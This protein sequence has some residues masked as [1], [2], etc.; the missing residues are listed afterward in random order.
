MGLDPRM[1]GSCPGPKAHAQP[2]SHPNVPINKLSKALTYAI[3]KKIATNEY[4]PW[5]SL[6]SVVL[7]LNIQVRKK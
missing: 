1:P 4:F 7:C 5:I 3:I 2:L 6:F